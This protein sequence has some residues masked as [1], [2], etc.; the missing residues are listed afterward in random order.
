MDGAPMSGPVDLSDAIIVKSGGAYCV[1][2]R[3]GSLPAGKPHPLGIYRQDA[4]HLKTHVLTLGGRRPVVR[5]ATDEE[6]SAA[7]H[8]LD[9]ARIERRI[10]GTDRIE[11][12]LVLSH[13]GEL[14]LDADFEDMLVVRGWAPPNDAPIERVA[15]PGGVRLARR[16]RDGVVRR[17]TVTADPPPLEVLDPAGAPAL[18]LPAGETR[19]TYVFEG[20]PG[21]EE[22]V[23]PPRPTVRTG[24]AR[25]DGILTRALRDVDTLRGSIDGHVHVTAGVPWYVALFGRDS[26][27]TAWQLAAFDPALAA[28]T[29]RLLAEHLGRRQDPE[30]EEEPGKVLHELRSGEVA[31]VGLS[32]ATRYYGS[33]DATA[34]WGCLL[35]EYVAW[36][37]DLGLFRELRPAV[38]ATLAWLGDRLLAYDPAPGAAL[39]N[40]GWKDSPDAIVDRE[41]RPVR[42][43]VTLVEP[44]GYAIRARQGLARL[45]EADGDRIRAETLRADADAHAARLESFWLPERACYAMA[46]GG[47]GVA[48]PALA[49]NQGHLLW[50]AGL[51]AARARAV[52]DAVMSPALFSGWGI[53]T[54]GE[55]EPGYDPLS[56]HRGSVWPH[57]TAITAVGLR[58]TGFDADFATLLDA[59]L[60]AADAASDRRL[61]EL[62]AGHP[63]APGRAPAGYPTACR[64]Q[65]WAAGSV[66]GLL[67]AAAGLVP[68]ALDGRLRLRA[69]VLPRGV[70]ELTIESLRIGEAEVDL[71]LTPDGIGDIAVRGPL[72][73][74]RPAR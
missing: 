34:L 30:R 35:A 50:S 59:L 47:D 68:D 69:P 73:V 63:R 26:L 4:R 74:E 45:F 40:Q 11:E 19:L 55:G 38:D 67:T 14:R 65:A 53:R 31:A 37:G 6:G 60:D 28:G 71:R 24:D 5:D 51:P 49:S 25:V 17:T 3:D 58:E 7:R 54:L 70:E 52:R 9:G 10:A 46:L 33:V 61:P 13:P 62:F 20:P 56:Y 15:V 32:P 72:E 57:D 66:P 27:I 18:R 12:R 48:T 64:P 8:D 44:Q 1:S 29:L 41:G 22:P 36:T 21:G 39:A 43:P 42:P 16:G 23:V 2:E